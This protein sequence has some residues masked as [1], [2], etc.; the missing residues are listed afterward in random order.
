MISIIEIDIGQLGLR[1]PRGEVGMVLAQ[2]YVDFE[3]QEPFRLKPELRDAAVAGIDATLA[4]ALGCAHGAEKTHFT[5]FPECTLPGLEGFDR[6]TTAM[7]EGRWPTGTVVIGGLEGL[8]RA[9]FNEL[10][11]RPNTT[12]DEEGS[13]LDRIRRD[14]WVNCCVTWVKLDSGEVRSWIQTKI[15]PAGVELQAHHQSMFKG[16][17]IFLFKGTYAETHKPY[18]FASLICFD[19]IGVRG[20]F[21]V[22]EWLLHHI[23]QTAGAAQV[24]L[25]LTWLFV[26]Q[27][28]PGPSHASFMSQVQPFFSPLR[29][30]NVLRDEACLIMANVA[31]NP[32]PGMAEHY[33]RSA[34]IFAT[35]K[36]TNPE[37]PPTHC[38]GGGIQ[39]PG[40]PLENLKDA[41]FRERGACIHSFRQLNPNTLVPGAAGKRFALADATVHAF[42]GTDDPRTPSGLVPAIVKWVNDELDDTEKSLESSYPLL[43]LAVNA[44]QAHQRSVS[45]LRML[46]PAELSKTMLVAS[47]G[48]GNLPDHWRNAQTQAVKHVLR[49][50]SILET[51]QYPA[52]FHGS[53]S[54]ATIMNGDIGIEVVAVIGRSHEECD[55]H[56]LGQLLGHRGQL[57]LVSRDEE[58]T[59]WDPRMRTLFDQAAEP[60]KELNITDPSSAVIRIGYHDLLKA[61][62]EAA[63]QAALR[64]VIDA[65]IS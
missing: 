38:N 58:N 56:V 43:P 22:W 19:W 5:I 42:Q 28:N 44:A 52:T 63:T 30:P 12:Y 36:F 27:C 9:E 33:G 2:P 24:D 17:S 54:Q 26:A 65:A 31:G 10:I 59:S 41:V 32:V 21:R 8:S 51:A 29:F 50:F 61:Y 62:R 4:V 45:A 48:A 34:V 57:L 37:N 35:P 40:N 46:S 20:E 13:S 25:P 64:E 16:R 14:Q 18:Q 23:D 60:T 15:E 11:Q 1:L 49:T 53:G 39:R 47:P 7:T 6:I 3:R 55:G